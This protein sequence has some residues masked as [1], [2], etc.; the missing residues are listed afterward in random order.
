MVLKYKKSCKY[1]KTWTNP[2]PWKPYIPDR[3]KNTLYI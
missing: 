1:L 2:N 3:I